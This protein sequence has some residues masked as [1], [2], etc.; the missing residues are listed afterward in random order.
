M[1]VNCVFGPCVNIA[2]VA[3]E[4]MRVAICANRFYFK[5]LF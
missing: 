4:I 3:L 2:L 5:G 1:K